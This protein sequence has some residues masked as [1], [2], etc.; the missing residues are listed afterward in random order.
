MGVVWATAIANLIG[1]CL[2][3]FVDS[4]IF[5]NKEDK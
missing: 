3:F 1:G 5:K 2:F 4:L